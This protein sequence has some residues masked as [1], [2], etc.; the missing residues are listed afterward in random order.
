MKPRPDYRLLNRLAIGQ[1]RS[2]TEV[3]EDAGYGY[4]APSRRETQLKTVAGEMTFRRGPG[5]IVSRERVRE[6]LDVVVE[7]RI[8]G[9]EVNLDLANK[10]LHPPE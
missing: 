10:P 5:D 7:T 2:I 1:D 3:D 8:V 9:P 6:G 4:P